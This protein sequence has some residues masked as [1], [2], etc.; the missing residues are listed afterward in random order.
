LWYLFIWTYHVLMPMFYPIPSSPSGT[1]EE[2]SRV[3]TDPHQISLGLRKAVDDTDDYP[4][5]SYE[6]NDLK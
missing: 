2:R 4:R 3:S 6:D 5:K 1:K